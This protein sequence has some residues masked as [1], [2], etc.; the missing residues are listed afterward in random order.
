MHEMTNEWLSSQKAEH[1]MCAQFFSVTYPLN[2]KIRLALK[3]LRS[4]AGRA[5]E[6]TARVRIY[7]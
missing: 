2:P 7:H 4:M 6:D 1:F 5:G 3:A